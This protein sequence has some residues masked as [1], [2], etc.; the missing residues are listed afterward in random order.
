[1]VCT[2]RSDVGGLFLS[3][4]L[5]YGRVCKWLED[6]CQ[7]FI[8]R[9]GYTLANTTADGVTEVLKESTLA[10]NVRFVMN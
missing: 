8:K 1:M 3:L 5:V 10:H 9:F 6:N 7:K 4:F 2:C